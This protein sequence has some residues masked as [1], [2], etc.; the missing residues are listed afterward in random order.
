MQIFDSFSEFE[1]YSPQAA[2]MVVAENEMQ[3]PNAKF[4]KGAAGHY[5]WDEVQDGP[6]DEDAIL[7]FDVGVTDQLLYVWLGEADNPD[8]VLIDEYSLWNAKSA[9]D[10]IEQ[11]K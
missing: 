7:L 11:V 5:Y 1:Q 9:L 3:Y 10:E 2:A 4:V 6:E 8:D